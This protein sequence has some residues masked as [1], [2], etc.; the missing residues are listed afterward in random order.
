ML[1]CFMEYKL[2]KLALIQT[3]ILPTEEI[4]MMNIKE[5]TKEWKLWKDIDDCL[6]L[7]TKTPP[8]NSVVWGIM[9][10]KVDR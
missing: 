8:K 9:W 4:L 5:A 1:N 6:H 7:L 2:N 3:P 10:D